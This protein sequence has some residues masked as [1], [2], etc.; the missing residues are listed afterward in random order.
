MSEGQALELHGRMTGLKL[1]LLGDGNRAS[2]A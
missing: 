1:R 2:A